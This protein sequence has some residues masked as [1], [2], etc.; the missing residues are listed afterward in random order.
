MGR[1]WGELSQLRE[2][3]IF[4]SKKPLTRNQFLSS[5]M[6]Y[7]PNSSAAKYNKK[8]SR[9]KIPDLL[10]YGKGRGKE[11]TPNKGMIGGEGRG[12]GREERW[13]PLRLQEGV[14]GG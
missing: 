10:E 13:I 7:R 5:R 2:C 3:Y 6:R 9:V 8:I 14:W 4:L 12:Y 11:V 1:G